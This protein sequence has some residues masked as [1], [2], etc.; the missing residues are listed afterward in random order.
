MQHRMREL[1]IARQA[2]VFVLAV[3]VEEAHLAAREPGAQRRR[4][5]VR[6]SAAFQAVKR[7][8]ARPACARNAPSRR[9]ST[10]SFG[11]SN[12]SMPTAVSPGA[13]PERHRDEEAALEGADLDDVARD[14]ELGLPPDRRGRRSPPRSATTCPRTCS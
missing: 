5:D 10:P 3:D 4:R 9:P 1:E 12:R 13:K 14:A 7:S 6:G 8:G 2:V 11:Q